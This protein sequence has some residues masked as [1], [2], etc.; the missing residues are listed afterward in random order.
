PEIWRTAD[1]LNETLKGKEITDLFFKFDELKDYESKLAGKKVTG[2]EARGKAMLTFFEG[3]Y[4]MYSHN[5]LYGIWKTTKNGHEPDTNRCLRVAIHNR[6]GSA[7]LYSA[8]PIEM[9]TTPQVG[10]HSSI[11]KLCPDVLH[12]ETTYED[13]IGHYRSET[14]KNRNLTS[15]LL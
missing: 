8:S 2:V 6:D 12:P 7:S 1:A 15:L 14:F 11:Q 5:Q 13:I 3:E 10:E 9:L 4:V